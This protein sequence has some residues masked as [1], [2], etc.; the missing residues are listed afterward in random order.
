MYERIWTTTETNMMRMSL[1]LKETITETINK[2]RNEWFSKVHTQDEENF[3]KKMIE[4]DIPALK[5]RGKPKN[6]W[7][8]QME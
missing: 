2:E 7:I 5:K 3:A 4:L 1:Q 8:S 6:G